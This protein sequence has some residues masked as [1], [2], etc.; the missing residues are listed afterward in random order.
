MTAEQLFPQALKPTLLDT[1]RTLNDILALALQG[2]A[3]A[4]G[5]GPMGVVMG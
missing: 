1:L 2:R 3:S 4:D 5:Y